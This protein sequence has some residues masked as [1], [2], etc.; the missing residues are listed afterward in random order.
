M[1]SSLS[2]STVFVPSSTALRTSVSHGL[3]GALYACWKL[4]R[5]RGLTLAGDLVDGD[6]AR[7]LGRVLVVGQVGA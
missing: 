4:Q 7:V 6:Q 2:A 3:L 5:D 1:I